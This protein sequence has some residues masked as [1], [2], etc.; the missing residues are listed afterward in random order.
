MFSGKRYVRAAGLSIAACLV[1]VAA[2]SQSPV[3]AMLVSGE[4]V[5]SHAL[6][7]G[8]TLLPDLT[9]LTVSPDGD[10]VLELYEY[11]PASRS[12]KLEV[13]INYGALR[14]I[15]GKI[16]KSADVILRTQ[17]ATIRTR[18]GMMAVVVDRNG[19]TTTMHVAGAYTRVEAAGEQL[20]LSRSN[21]VAT[22]APG[23]APVYEGVGK[24]KDIA[25]I[26]ERTKV[27]YADEQQADGESGNAQLILVGADRTTDP[28]S[29]IRANFSENQDNPV[30]PDLTDQPAPNFPTDVRVNEPVST[31]DFPALTGLN[32]FLESCCGNADGVAPLQTS[33]MSDLSIGSPSVDFSVQ[34][35]FKRFGFAAFEGQVLDSTPGDRISFTG[36][37]SESPPLLLPQEGETKFRSYSLSGDLNSTSPA[38]ARLDLLG[39]RGNVATSGTLSLIDAPSDDARAVSGFLIIKGSGIKQTSAFGVF[40]GNVIDGLDAPLFFDGEFEGSKAGGGEAPIITRSQ[41]GSVRNDDGFAVFG[42]DANALIVSTETTPGQHLFANGGMIPFS[43]TSFATLTSISTFQDAARSTLSTLD[44]K[45]YAATG[46]FDLQTG[47]AYA[48]RSSGFDGLSLTTDLET[49]SAVAVIRLNTAVGLGAP[50]ATP[51]GD[52]GVFQLGASFGGANGKSA[53]IDDRHL[54]LRGV[55]DQFVGAMASAGLV[56]NGDIFPEGVTTTPEYLSWGW[57]AGETPERAAPYCLGCQPLDGAQRVHLGSWIGGDRTRAANLP[58]SGVA[59]YTGFAAVSAV[60]N[61]VG[62][63]DGAGFQ[64]EWDFADRSGSARFSDLL[65]ADATIALSD[66]QRSGF[67]G[68]GAI[69]IDGLRGT[70]N[71]DGSFFN[72]QNRDPAQAAAGSLVIETRDA[73]I[74]ATGV[75]GGDRTK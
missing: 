25:A 33:E 19:G 35:D 68:T 24:Q 15:G 75:F 55:S 5:E 29:P 14:L 54:A 1:A 30:D 12:G 44:L 31:E 57:W 22:I 34:A 13:S 20:T 56:G 67:S 65:G 7:A 21:A 17:A 52:E 18:G 38:F 28:I 53:A 42:P 63:V 46:A 8:Q 58:L 11:D 69:R 71:V 3:G 40:T 43:T 47:D 37:M 27:A 48:A 74:V 39:V 70:L 50:D 60:Q 41:A 72:G 6:M 10:M 51:N 49:N 62:F 36:Q 2:E 9:S 59:T 73:S 16:P 61:G 45:G 23:A 32:I 4:K 66:T 64:M 26:Y